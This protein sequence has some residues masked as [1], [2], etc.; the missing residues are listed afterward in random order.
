MRYNKMRNKIQPSDRHTRRLMTLHKAIQV[1]DDIE[2]LNMKRKNNLGKC[3]YKHIQRLTC[4][5]K[6]KIAKKIFYRKLKIVKITSGERKANSK[7]DKK[8]I[9]VKN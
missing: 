9:N 7:L 5:I 3:V 2:R 8:N 4:Q 1:K 6:K